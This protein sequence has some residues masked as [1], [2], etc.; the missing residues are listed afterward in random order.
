LKKRRLLNIAL[1][2]HLA[3]NAVYNMNMREKTY[4]TL[5]D[6]LLHAMDRFSDSYKSRSDFVEAAVRAFISQL[7]RNQQNSRDLEVINRHAD[8]LNQ[9][10][11]DVLA[12]QVIP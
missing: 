11:L 4:V 8:E 3:A 1:A 10:A 6:D 12:Y 9:E 5:P 2:K 7:A